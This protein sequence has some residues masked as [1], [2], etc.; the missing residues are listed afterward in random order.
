MATSLHL[1]PSILFGLLFLS[2]PTLSRNFIF[3]DDTPIA[4][5]PSDDTTTSISLLGS[6]DIIISPSPQ[7]SPA[8]EPV[9]P[10]STGEDQST[11]TPSP[12]VSSDAFQYLDDSFSFL[13]L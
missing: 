10:P 11:P 8:D 4:P 5:S 12:E 9:S 13:M 1:L 6:G 7:D 2:A 3:L